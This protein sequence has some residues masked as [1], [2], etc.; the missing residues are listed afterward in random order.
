MPHTLDLEGVLNARDLGGLPTADG[1]RVATG[2]LFRSGSLHQMRG[3]D[4]TVLEQ[5]GVRTVIDLR[6]EWEIRRDAYEWD[7]PIVHAP[8][9]S[10]DQVASIH[11]RFGA[12][13]LSEADLADWWELTRVPHAL[14]TRAGSI[15]T[16]FETLLQGE[17]GI[18]FHCTVGKDRTGLVAALILWALGVPARD[19]TEDFTAST[20]ALAHLADD[21]AERLRAVSGVTPSAKALASLTG[22]KVEWL[23][24]LIRSIDGRYGSVGAYLTGPIGMSS[25]D[26]ADLRRRYLANDST[27]I[28]R[29]LR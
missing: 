24:Q 9:V 19:I 22:V 7:G 11:A 23:D 4:R 20:A 3:S 21:L 1:R 16:V 8:L 26:L 5:A 18:L 2:V 27:P 12:G 17:I 14:E 25:D 13:T 10:D 29:D 28:P 15:R 6:S